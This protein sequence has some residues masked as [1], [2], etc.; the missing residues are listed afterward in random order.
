MKLTHLLACLGAL[1]GSGVFAGRVPYHNVAAARHI[2]DLNQGW[3]FH[4]GADAPDAPSPAYNDAG[5]AQVSLPHTWNRL[6]AYSITRAPDAND[7]QGIGTY[8]LHFTGPKAD[9]TKR[10]Y[11]Q[12][13]GVGNIAT[14]WLNGVKLGEHRGAFSRFRFDVTGL[15]KA[16]ADNILVVQADNSKP[17][18]GASTQDVIPLGADFFIY[19]GIYRGVSLISANATSIDLMDYA[20]PGVYAHTAYIGADGATIAVR[21]QVRGVVAGGVPVRAVVAIDDAQDR[22]AAP[23]L[24]IPVH[25]TKAGAAEISG[26]LLLRHPHLWNGR[27]DPYL[28]HLSVSLYRSGQR[29]DAVTVPLGV[30]TFRVDA[31][32]G[33]FLNGKHLALVGAARHQ[34]RMGKGWAL[35]PQDHAE[36]MQIMADMGANTV[37][38]AH[39][40]HAQEWDDAAD[41]TGMVA[42]AEIPFV[43]AASFGDGEPAT[44][45]LKANARQQLR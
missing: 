16:G 40:Q 29:L 3:R 44:E 32:K 38:M 34:D 41:R 15:L 1:T 43:N 25:A 9:A 18:P 21:A 5:W 23:P 45:A 26:T 6:G 30:R 14:V 7:K 2:E 4:F 22:P 31:D 12:F 8:R 17:A 28:Y 19:G 27:A 10:H 35:S 24:M 36:D 37:R 42:W 39:Y 20:G 13:D 11:L 33:F